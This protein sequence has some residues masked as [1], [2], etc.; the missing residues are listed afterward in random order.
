[1]FGVRKN[2]DNAH[3]T[4]RSDGQQQASQE[5]LS[6]SVEGREESSQKRMAVCPPTLDWVSKKREEVRGYGNPLAQ[7]RVHATWPA[8]RSETAEK[9][10]ETSRRRRSLRKTSGERPC[11]TREEDP[12]NAEEKRLLAGQ[13]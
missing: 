8:S 4:E 2:V 5:W 11:V 12:D 1:M 6:L 13:D 7:Q 3:L 9:E 10:K